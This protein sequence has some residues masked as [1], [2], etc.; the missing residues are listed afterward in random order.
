MELNQKQKQAVEMAEAW[1]QNPDKQIFKLAG[2]AGTGKTTTATTIAKMLTGDADTLFCAFTGKA[3]C[4]MRQKGMPGRT[5]HSA[6]YNFERI[7]RKYYDED[8][9]EKKRYYY[10]R[11]RK[12]SLPYKLIIVDE[13]SMVG[14]DVAKDLLSFGIPVLAIG[15]PGQLPPVGDC[16]S[17]MLKNPDIVLDEIMRQA[18]G[19]RIPL[20]AM[21][22]RK[23]W[24]PKAKDFP[25]GPDVKVV[26]P[27]FLIKHFPKIL[28]KAD[29]IIC[30]KNETREVLNDQA[31][32]FYRR[33]K[34]LN[35]GE[36][37][38]RKENDWD[39]VVFSKSI[40]DLSLVNGM[41]G[42][43]SNVRSLTKDHFMFDFTPDCAKDATFHDLAYNKFDYAYAIT[44]HASQGS[45]YPFV[46]VVD[47]SWND[48]K[49]PDFQ[50]EWRYT[51]ATRAKEKLLW[52]TNR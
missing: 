33:E 5:I 16:F 24:E 2:Y 6:I 14:A 42:I 39:Q 29:Q 25:P 49:N 45:E 30:A 36:K 23:G 44:C 31:R 28:E 50:A 8:G 9:E 34:K 38:V 18:D 7:E 3:A 1:F 12:Y 13:A 21:Q 43:A 27:D 11:H 40:G 22:L 47:D 32:K 19:N 48:Y 17:N 35:E 26:Q 46:V 52:V 51:A 4:V 10:V 20:F 15:D 37:I 41:T